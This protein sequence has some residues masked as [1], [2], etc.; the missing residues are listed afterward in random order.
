MKLNEIEIIEKFRSAFQLQRK[1]LSDDVAFLG[2]WKGTTVLKADMFVQGTDMPPGMTLRQA[3]RKAVVACLSDL[4]CKG[5][6]P[7]GFV[8]SLALPRKLAT[9]KDVKLLVAGVKDASDEFGVPLVGGDVNES[10]ELVID[11][12]MMGRVVRQVTRGGA[13][14]GDLLVTTGPFGY[15]SLGLKHLLHGS[16]IPT[17]LKKKALECVLR[18]RPRPRLCKEL[19]DA[20]CVDASMDSSDGL[21]ITLNEMA[22]QSD[23]KLVVTSLPADRS[24]MENCRSWTLNPLE[25]VMYGGEEY[26]A[27]LSIPRAKWQEAKRIAAR[28]N[29]ALYSFGF[30][31]EG[32][33]EVV[34][35]PTPGAKSSRIDPRG[36]IHLQ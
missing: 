1:D 8:V 18:P 12:A 6:E 20:D 31:A 32:E 17:A 11:C 36:W 35:R 34:Y 14:P 2:E 19:I 16:S 25:L 33:H 24:F 29:E 28:L 27:V 15:S 22:L 21:A 30:V 3:S 9:A 10:E 23:K 26:E 7:I 13:A 5:A 4:A